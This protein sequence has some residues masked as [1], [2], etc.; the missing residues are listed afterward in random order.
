MAKNENLEYETHKHTVGH[1]I[2]REKTEKRGKLEIHS[3]GPV[4]WR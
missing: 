2:W 4:R 3:V 1:G